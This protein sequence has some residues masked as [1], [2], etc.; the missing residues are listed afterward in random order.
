MRQEL[1]SEYVG[2]RNEQILNERI[3]AYNKLKWARIGDYLYYKGEYV[4]FTHDWGD[5]LQTSEGEGSFYLGKGYVSY[6]GS[7]NTGLSKELI[8][9]AG[10]RKLGR[11]WF[12]D[13]DVWGAGRGVNFEIPFRVFKVKRGAKVTDWDIL[14]RDIKIRRNK[15]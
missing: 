14:G 4:R 8:Q 1:E 6:S 9:Y 7:L 10:K 12:F 5:S 3:K 13:S 15:K 11:V 2:N